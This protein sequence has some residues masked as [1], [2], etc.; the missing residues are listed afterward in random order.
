MKDNLLISLALYLVFFYSLVL[1]DSIYQLAHAGGKLASQGF[2]QAMLGWEAAFEGVD[3]DVVKVAIHFIIH[4][5]ISA[6]VGLQ[7]LSVTHG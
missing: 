4:I 1:I 3:G 7:G 2:P 6:R 5:L